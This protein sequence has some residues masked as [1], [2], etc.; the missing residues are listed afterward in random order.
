MNFSKCESTSLRTLLGAF[1]IDTH[2]LAL[3]HLF[4]NCLKPEAQGKVEAK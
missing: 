4:M 2:N 1:T 3:L